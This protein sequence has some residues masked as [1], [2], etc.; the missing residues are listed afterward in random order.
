M[1]EENVPEKCPCDCLGFPRFFSRPFLLGNET[2]CRGEALREKRPHP[3]QAP[4]QPGGSHLWCHL[5]SNECSFSS[6]LKS[7]LGPVRNPEALEYL[8]LIGQFQ[9]TGLHLYLLCVGLSFR[10]WKA[11]D[12][13]SFYPPSWLQRLGS[14]DCL[15]L[16]YSQPVVLIFLLALLI[17]SLQILHWPLWT[18]LQQLLCDKSAWRL[19]FGANLTVGPSSQR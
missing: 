16:P 19:M 8:D 11:Q 17:V 3:S 7:C 18:F 12:V 5:K 4:P 14:K 10:L 6:V 2:E 13:I 15:L 1:T 9:L